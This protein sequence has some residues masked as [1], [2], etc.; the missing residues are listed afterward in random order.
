MAEK[1]AAGAASGAP[2][3]H[4]AASVLAATEFER[5]V[6]QMHALN[7]AD[8]AQPTACG[9][10]DVR[11]VAAPM[12]PVAGLKGIYLFDT[13]RGHRDHLADMIYTRDTWMHR[14]D[15]SWATGR[16][17]RISRPDSGARD[18]GN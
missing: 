4:R 11:A 13:G 5:I 8:W 9:W 1:T 18:R 17:S 10:W 15:I 12:R 6:A 16:P 14:L 3:E 7:P 2:L